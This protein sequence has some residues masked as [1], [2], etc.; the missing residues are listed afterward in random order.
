MI[1]YTADTHFGFEPILRICQRPFET[2]EEHDNH[3]ISQI[4]HMVLPDDTLF[5]LGDFGDNEALSKIGCKEVH[6]IRGNHDESPIGFTT[7]NDTMFANGFWLS[8]YPHRFWPKSHYGS[9]HL[10]GHTHGV[11]DGLGLSLDVGVDSAY[12]HFRDFRPF[13]HEDIYRILG[14][15]SAHDRV[16]DYVEFDRLRKKLPLEEARKLAFDE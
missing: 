4:N 12:Q 9:I 5:V 14:P 8:H 3:L 1:F 16:E 6:L 11:H 7:I 10:F 15:R 2:I 13:S